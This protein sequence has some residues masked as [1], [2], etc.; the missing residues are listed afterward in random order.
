[1]VVEDIPLNANGKLDIF[2][3]TRERIG[4]EAYDLVPVFTDG[5]LTDIQTK[6][7]ENVNSM[8]AGT[9]PHGMENHSA[10]NMF[11]FFN[12]A[13]P[14]GKTAGSSL[15]AASGIFGVLF[16][17]EDRSRKRSSMPEIP[18]IVRKAVL[19]YGNRMIGMISTGRKTIDFDFEDVS[20]R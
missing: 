7:V 9:V 19:K 12:A 8:T 3:I 11:D 16:P 17:D 6:H 13:A 2:R 4:G 5:K 20:E 15:H 10:Y 1:M 18:E 14:S